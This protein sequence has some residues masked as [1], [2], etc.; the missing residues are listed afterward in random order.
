LARHGFV[1]ND[2]A[3]SWHG[4]AG[5]WLSSRL[6]TRNRMT[7]HDAPLSVLRAYTPAELRNLLVRAGIHGAVVRRRPLFR[8]T[9]VKQHPCEQQ[10]ANSLPHTVW[11]LNQPGPSFN[12]AQDAH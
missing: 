4:Y 1:L 10:H 12:Q 11:R 9:A 5:A 3:R 8:M 7:R 6:A 2:L